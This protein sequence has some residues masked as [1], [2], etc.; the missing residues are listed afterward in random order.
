MK[1]RSLGLIVMAGSI[2][3]IG[4][5]IAGLAQQEAFDGAYKGSLDCEQTPTT[6]LRTSLAMTARNGRII[7]SLD[8]FDISGNREFISELAT[9]TVR[10]DGTFHMADTVYTRVATFQGAYTGAFSANGGIMTGTQVWTR[11]PPVGDG[12]TCFCYGTF[13]KVGAL[14]QQ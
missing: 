5:P 7:A 8:L 9:G 10:A 12:V 6:T 14:G 11:V 2:I 1:V 3:A 13:V 4:A